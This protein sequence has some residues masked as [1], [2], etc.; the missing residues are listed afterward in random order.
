VSVGRVRRDTGPP[1]RGLVRPSTEVVWDCFAPDVWVLGFSF[2]FACLSMS[3]YKI[4]R[5]RR[6]KRSASRKQS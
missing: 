6:R 3:I 1:M 4:Y 2:G 5:E